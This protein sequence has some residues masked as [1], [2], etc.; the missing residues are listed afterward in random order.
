[1]IA[2]SFMLVQIRGGRATR[3]RCQDTRGTSGDR[4][5]M[6]KPAPLIKIPRDKI[7]DEMNRPVHVGWARPG[8]VWILRRIE[9]EIAHLETPKTHRWS[10]AHL[11]Q[12]FYSRR[13]EPRHD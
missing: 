7:S 10:K 6:N 3:P 2:G 11:D 5:T 8:C 9:G 1:M 12:L 4:E 13:R